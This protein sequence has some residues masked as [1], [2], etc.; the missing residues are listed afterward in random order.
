MR[1]LIMVSSVSYRRYV[2][3]YNRDKNERKGLSELLILRQGR[4][5]GFGR[6]E[7]KMES[8][9]QKLV[10]YKHILKTLAGLADQ[11]VRKV[12]GACK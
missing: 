5:L 1:S 2:N 12:S 8:G 6:T 4:K 9:F 7:W 11:G 3:K 10:G